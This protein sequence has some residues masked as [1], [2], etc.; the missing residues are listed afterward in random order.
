VTGSEE[1]KMLTFVS[2]SVSV[3]SAFRPSSFQ[4]EKTSFSPDIFKDKHGKLLN[5]EGW[6]WKCRLEFLFE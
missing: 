1:S 5:K 6:E 3:S 2:L 4:E